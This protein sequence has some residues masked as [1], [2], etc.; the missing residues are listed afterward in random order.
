MRVMDNLMNDTLGK[1][2][3]HVFFSPRVDIVEGDKAFRIELALPGMKKEQ[4][5]LMV[6]NNQLTVSGER[7]I[8]KEE[9]ER[10][11][12]VENFYG[13]FSRTFSLPE[14]TDE[15]GITAELIDG[16]LQIGIP[17]VEEQVK[18]TSIE[19]K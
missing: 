6:E 12:V 15:V 5:T 1:L 3:R 9:N 18:K 11:R 14:G 4:I 10:H 7:K 8:H 16:I 19:I 17:K 13:K 2:D